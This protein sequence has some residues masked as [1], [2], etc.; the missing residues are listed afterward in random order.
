MRLDEREIPGA[1]ESID[2]APDLFEVRVSKRGRVPEREWPEVEASEPRKKQRTAAS[3]SLQEPLPTPP[4]TQNRAQDSTNS[5]AIHVDK[6]DLGTSQTRQK[7]SKKKHAWETEYEKLKKRLQ[8][9]AR[10]YLVQLIGNDEYPEV[11]RV[12]IVPPEILLDCPIVPDDPLSVWRHFISKEDLSYIAKHTNKQAIAAREEQR[13]KR[14]VRQ[15]KK[16][17]WKKVTTAEIGGYFGAL[18]LLGTQGAAS[19]CDNWKASE[20]SPLYPL[21]RHISLVRFQ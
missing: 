10:D 14:P 18:F 7:K 2:D 11:L 20:D 9:C 13:L 3:A 19:L 12:P 15:K 4:S 21:R 5:F 16:R 1:S 6:F 8:Q 17:P